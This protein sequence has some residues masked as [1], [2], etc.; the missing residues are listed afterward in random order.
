MM[1]PDGDI[2]IISLLPSLEIRNWKLEIF[3]P[4][5]YLLAAALGGLIAFFYSIPAIL[6]EITKRG[7]VPELP[8]LVD[9]KTIFRRRLNVKEV[10]WAALLLEILLGVGF[11]VAYIWFT[12]HDW[13]FVTHAPYSLAS[14]LIFALGAFCVTGVMIFPALGMG[15][16][17]RREGHRVWLEILTSF[18]LISFTLWLIIRFYQP[19]YFG[20]VL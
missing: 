5:D 9:V 13:L 18:L 4:M 16:F 14:L 6:L 8:L 15:L 11:G 1:E 20:N 7:D 10:F 3:K 19:F 2:K 12:T 17:G